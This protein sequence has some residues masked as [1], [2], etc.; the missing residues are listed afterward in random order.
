MKK[1]EIFGLANEMDPAH[2]LS[3]YSYWKKEE[4]K[5]YGAYRPQSTFPEH[6]AF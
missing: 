5:H 1:S 2:F 3:K 4:K 6:A